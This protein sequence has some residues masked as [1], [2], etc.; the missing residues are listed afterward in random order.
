LVPE[1]DV[2][3]NY[4]TNY[5]NSNV[6]DNSELSITTA[7]RL[8][9]S[10]RS[11]GLNGNYW[12]SSHLNNKSV[13]SKEKPKVS[14]IDIE[15]YIHKGNVTYQSILTSK[16]KRK[17]DNRYQVKNKPFNDPK[18]SEVLLHKNSINCKFCGAK[19][20][21][22]KNLRRHILLVHD[23]IKRFNCEKCSFSALETVSLKTHNIRVHDEITEIF[24]CTDCSFMTVL[25]R[26]WRSHLREVHKIYKFK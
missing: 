24:E 12:S 19:I 22:P 10:D 18:T 4:E 25:K 16:S 15:T 17:S 1:N 26:S 7:N 14:T 23:K 11:T 13:T 3:K 5:D 20:Y 2:L 6:P 21:D 8:N 9:P